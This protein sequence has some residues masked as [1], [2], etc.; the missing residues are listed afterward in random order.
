MWFTSILRACFQNSRS[1]SPAPT[2]KTDQAEQ[3]NIHDEIPLRLKGKTFCTSSLGHGEKLLDSLSTG[4][5]SASPE[6]FAPLQSARRVPAVSVG[7]EQRPGMLTMPD[8]LEIRSP[9]DGMQRTPLPL[10]S[11]S[12][13]S[14]SPTLQ[15]LRTPM[16]FGS[17][18]PYPQSHGRDPPGAHLGLL[19]EQERD[20]QK[21][22]AEQRG[23]PSLPYSLPYEL[24]QPSDTASRRCPGVPGSPYVKEQQALAQKKAFPARA[25]VPFTELSNRSAEECGTP[26]SAPLTFKLSSQ[27]QGRTPRISGIEN[28]ATSY[29]ENKAVMMRHTPFAERVDRALANENAFRASLSGGHKRSGLRKAS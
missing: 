4:S 1:A 11:P 17:P 29:K 26:S 22:Q 21:S 23:I 15:I 28:P 3:A 7:S 9:T 19:T 14:P 10:T 20:Q 27:G 2:V 12:L 13:P 24:R 8:S 18:V 5:Q 16:P 25:E 6:G